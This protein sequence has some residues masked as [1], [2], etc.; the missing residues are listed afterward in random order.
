MDTLNIVESISVILASLAT[1]GTVMYGIK[2]W[3]DEYRGKRKIELMEEVLA[4]FYEAR[5]AISYMRN[6]FAT[7]GEGSSRSPSPNETPE[8]KD[9]N[10]NAY[11]V[12]ERY[13]KRQE[14]FNKLYSIRYRYMAQFGGKSIQPFNE[15]TKIINEIFVAARMLSHIWKRQS[16]IQL[17]NDEEYQK[18]LKEMQRYEAIFWYQGNEEDSINARVDIIISDIEAQASK[19]VGTSK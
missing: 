3:R 13:N 7:A 18:H 5:D 6:P 16:F 2:S 17:K 9:I 11:V 14:L 10:N 1:A 12:V 8:E 19:V 4:L 15:L